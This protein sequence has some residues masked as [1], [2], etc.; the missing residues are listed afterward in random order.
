[1][2]GDQL[3][4]DLL[5]EIGRGRE[6]GMAPPQLFINTKTLEL[7]RPPKNNKDGG[8]EDVEPE[9]I[10]EQETKKKDKVCD[11]EASDPAEHTD[12]DGDDDEIRM[13]KSLPILSYMLVFTGLAI[14]LLGVSFN[15][16]GGMMKYDHLISPDFSLE[17]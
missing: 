1:M 6:V 4:S 10:Q 2:L 12:A 13:A 9:N 17:R 11:S 14:A 3:R 5:C 8:S 16:I 7:E 15:Q